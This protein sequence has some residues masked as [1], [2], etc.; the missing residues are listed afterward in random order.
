MLTSSCCPRFLWTN[1]TDNFHFC[2][3]RYFI[4]LMYN[5]RWTSDAQYYIIYDEKKQ[6]GSIKDIKSIRLV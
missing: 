3:S 1:A 4:M 2:I 5:F 6:N